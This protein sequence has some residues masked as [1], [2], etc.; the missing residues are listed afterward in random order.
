MQPMRRV[1]NNGNRIFLFPDKLQ[2][3][4]HRDPGGVV[5]IVYKLS[6]NWPTFDADRVLVQCVLCC[7]PFTVSQ[8]SVLLDIYIDYYLY[9][10]VT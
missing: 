1:M 7:C 9:Y 6:S 10:I 4:I 5:V 2:S 3:S 8:Y